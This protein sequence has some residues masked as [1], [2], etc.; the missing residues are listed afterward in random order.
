M[1]KGIINQVMLKS[2]GIINKLWSGQISLRRSRRRSRRS[3]SGRR[4]NQT[5][6]IYLPSK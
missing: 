2:K 1:S 3:G 5:K 4:K 6:T